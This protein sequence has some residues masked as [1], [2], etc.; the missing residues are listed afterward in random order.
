M[1]IKKLI[2]VISLVLALTLAMGA[3]ASAA[4]VITANQAKAIALKHAGLT[5]AQVT[6]MRVKL[7]RDDG[8]QEYEVDFYKG[9]VE[10]EYEIDAA[11]GKIRSFDKEVEYNKGSGHKARCRE[12]K[13]Y[14]RN[15]FSGR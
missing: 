12:F 14:A 3:F 10:Y 15:Y 11:T 8:R 6:R 7:D 9:S 13:A 4:T 1:K 5:E 2:A